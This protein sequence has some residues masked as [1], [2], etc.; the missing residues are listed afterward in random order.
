MNI[1]ILYVMY[2]SGSVCREF[3]DGNGLSSWSGSRGRLSV[4]LSMTLLGME[5]RTSEML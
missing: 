2:L 1:A 3:R 5:A 4:S